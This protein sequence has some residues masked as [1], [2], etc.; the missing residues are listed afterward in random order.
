MAYDFAIKHTP[1]ED[2]GHSDAMSR[3][4]FKINDTKLVD[5]TSTF[6][7]PVVDVNLLRK[8]LQSENFA[9]RIIRRIK[10]DNWSECSK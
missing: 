7:K 6:E 2:I 4:A 5:Q 3:L 9:P 1:G 8:E 10:N